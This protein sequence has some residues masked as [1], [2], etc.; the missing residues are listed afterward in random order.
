M[1]LSYIYYQ[2]NN[3]DIIYRILSFSFINYIAELNVHSHEFS[4]ICYIAAGKGIYTVNGK[5]YDLEEGDIVINCKGVIHAK[6][7]LPNKEIDII[8]IQFSPSV[9]I[10]SSVFPFKESQRLKTYNDLEIKDLF[11]DLM[12]EISKKKSGYQD[13]LKLQV[14]RL[15][16]YLNRII[17]KEYEPLQTNPP[18]SDYFAPQDNRLLETIKQNIRLNIDKNLKLDE[19]TFG[20]YRSPQYLSQI[21]KKSEGYTIKEYDI[22]FK[23]DMVKEILLKSDDNINKIAKNVGYTNIN[24]FYRLFKKH[25]NMTP[26]EYREFNK[27]K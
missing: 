6:G 9:S 19:I 11:K 3:S 4:E 21:F 14:S 16:L 24:Y 17:N 25:T 26:T 27:V 2:N 18:F 15:I 12:I 8:Y 22:N 23:L 13:I 1:D 10:N 7:S 5:S 20:L